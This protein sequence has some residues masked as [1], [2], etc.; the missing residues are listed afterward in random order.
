MAH[1]A[2]DR[3]INADHLVD[4]GRIDVDMRLLGL[5]AEGIDAP[6]DPVVKTRTDVDHQI[7]VVH[8]H[9][10]LIETMHAQHADPLVTRRWI[11]TQ[12]HQR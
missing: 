8:R 12:P 6:G 11:T 2:H 9:I 7:A 1:I 10:G 3:D 4:G 5:G